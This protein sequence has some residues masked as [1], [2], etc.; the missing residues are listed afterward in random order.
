MSQSIRSD[1]FSQ[2]AEKTAAAER[3]IQ[4]DIDRKEKAKPYQDN[5]KSEKKAAMQA[6]ARIYPEPP[7]PRIT[8][9]RKSSRT[10]WR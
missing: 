2:A 10:R 3:A 4:Q 1:R 6:G 8:R 7:L 9:D 5:E